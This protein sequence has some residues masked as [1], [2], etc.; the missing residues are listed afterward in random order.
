MAVAATG[1]GYAAMDKS[2]TLSVDGKT[3]EVSTLGSTVGDVLNSQDISVGRH[4]VVAP[5]LGSPINDGSTVAVRYGRPLD[6]K[7]DGKP[8]HYWVTATDVAS[9]LSQ[10]GVRYSNADLSSSRSAT[11][12]RSGMALTVVTPKKL[13][14]KIGDTKLHKKTLTAL[15]VHQA[16]DKLG[17][18]VTKDDH[19]T[20]GLGAT[21]K[22][23]DKIVVTKVNTLTKKV[24]E[25]IAYS[26]V[27]RS[28]SSM[29]S[30]QSKTLRAGQ[31]GAR[32]VVYRITMHNGHVVARKVLHSTVTS[33]P[34]NAIVKVGTKSRPAPTSNFASGNTVWDQI[35]QCESGGNWAENT[36]NGYY[37]GLQFDLSTWHSYGGSGYPSDNSRE[38][39]IAIATKVRDA[40]GGYGSWPS[41]SQQLGLPQ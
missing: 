16:L 28:D 20:P 13:M 6:V 1:V 15:T 30:G 25:S 35:A 34:V 29:F 39:Q 24:T 14:I 17:V 40:N 8:S 18:K 26:T 27:K 2:V 19:V 10:I 23:G 31:N 4:D 37:G 33:K 11:I 3:R 36:G 9:A 5:G 38:T 32:H 12:G 21:L 7:V 41:C 22:D